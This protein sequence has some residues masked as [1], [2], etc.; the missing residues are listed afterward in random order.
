MQHHHSFQT[1]RV[2]QGQN[3]CV[4][5]RSRPPASRLAPAAPTRTTATTGPASPPPRSRATTS[6][7][8]ALA[9]TAT[10]RGPEPLE[11]LL[12]PRTYARHAHAAPVCVLSLQPPPRWN[13]RT[14]APVWS[15]TSAA[16]ALLTRENQALASAVMAST[17]FSTQMATTATMKLQV[18][19]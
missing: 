19:T 6:R 2:C 4:L 11:P 17:S 18:S 5:D 9:A 8:P 7:S 13:Q 12:T 14:R 10:G 15:L 3:P 16:L 1:E